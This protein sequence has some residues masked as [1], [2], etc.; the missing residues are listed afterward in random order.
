M[1]ALA[2]EVVEELRADSPAAVTLQPLPAAHADRTLI[3]QVWTNLI[4][5]AF[6]YSAKRAQ[7]SIEIGGREEQAE[8]TYWVR[9]N[10]AGFDMRYVAK[11]FGVFQRLHRDDE[12]PGTGVGLAIVQRVVTRHGGRAW[13]EGRPGEGACFYFSLPGAK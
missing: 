10:G 4:G 7:A 1:T 13:A 9:D 5:N 12:F 6:K 11:L 2:R 3:R 8:N